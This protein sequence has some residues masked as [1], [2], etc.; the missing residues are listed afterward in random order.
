MYGEIDPNEVSMELLNL[1]AMEYFNND[2]ADT[3]LSL[4]TVARTRFP[5]DMAVSS[6]STWS[7]SNFISRAF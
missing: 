6:S 4:L 2:D 5:D 7:S 1:V 3:A